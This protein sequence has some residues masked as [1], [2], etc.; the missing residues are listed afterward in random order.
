MLAI[1]EPFCPLST[2]GN[3]ARPSAS[4]KARTQAQTAVVVHQCGKEITAP[5][6]LTEIVT[7]PE[8][9][10][11]ILD[12]LACGTP[13]SVIRSIFETGYYE[14][15]VPS[16]SSSAPYIAITYTNDEVEGYVYDMNSQPPQQLDLLIVPMPGMT[17][18][19]RGEYEDEEIWDGL[20]WGSVDY[21]DD[22]GE[23]DSIPWPVLFT[24]TDF[25]DLEAVSGLEIYFSGGDDRSWGLCTPAMPSGIEPWRL[26]K[27]SSS[28]P[29]QSDMWIRD[30]SDDYE[31]GDVQHLVVCDEDTNL[32]QDSSV[33]S[34]SNSESEMEWLE[35]AE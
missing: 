15:T 8:A 6:P 9:K 21:L 2:M 20:Q 11:V 18:V 33:G 14:V 28:Q 32:E 27:S 23:V 16:Q 5:H 29:P 35:D 12:L 4:R 1:L 31:L 19:D 24:S 25:E 13:E 17:S 7:E 22:S 26:S 34:T 3:T 30:W 10:Q